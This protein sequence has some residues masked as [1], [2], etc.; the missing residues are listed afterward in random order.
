MARSITCPTISSKEKTLGAII[1]DVEP[2][3]KGHIDRFGGSPDGSVRYMI[4]P[5]LPFR[6]E[7]DL[8]PF[9]K[10]AISSKRSADSCYQCFD[11]DYVV[12][13]DRRQR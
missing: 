11:G 9:H 4:A 1:L 7:D 3:L 6:T 5:Y 10:C 12:Q 13:H 8:Y 2:R